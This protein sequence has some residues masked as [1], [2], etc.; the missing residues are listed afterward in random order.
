VCFASGCKT[1]TGIQQEGDTDAVQIA[2]DSYEVVTGSTERQTV[3]TGFL[4][5]GDVADLAMISIDR[6]GDRRLHLYTLG[7][8]TW[9]PR[10]SATLRPKVLFVDIARIG[11]RDRLIT[12]ESGRLNWFDP[13]SKTERLLIE[14]T[15]AYN[16][17]DKSEIPQMKITRDVNGDGYDDILMPDVD[18]FWISIQLN[19]GS[20]TNAVKLGPSEPFRSQ[21]GVDDSGMN[22]S[23]TYGEV[24]ITRLTFP[25][26][27]SRVHQVDFNQDGR[28]DL[29]FWNED[30]FDV[31]RQN[32]RG[33]FDPVP[34][35]FTAYVPFDSEGSYSRV[36]DYS[37]SGIF[38]MLFGLGE[39]TTRTVLHSMRDLNGDRVADL[40]TLAFTGRSML[41]QRS[42]Y[43]VHFG[44]ASPDGISF[45]REVGTRIHP[46][47]RAGGA[48]TWGY[49]THRFEDFD[50]DGQLDAMFREVNIGIGGMVRALLAN[51]VS[52]NLE[53]Y[54]MEDGLY[55]DK[56]TTRKIRP[57]L[58][59]FSSREAIFFPGALM[60]DVNGDGRSDLLVG[61]SREELHIY[62][63]VPGPNLLAQNPQKVKVALPADQD[64]DIWLSD[65][66]KDG[67]QDV[68]IYHSSNSEP[69][70]VTML[71][72]R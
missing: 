69:H 65:L 17:T 2:F 12:Y 28:S 51:S 63:G 32:E 34:K 3:L 64:R 31:Y 56:P 61:E 22:G 44:K 37:D 18:G 59:P 43:E 21:P 13:D 16:A 53:F 29:V 42:R 30:H 35:T 70:R 62:I 46:Q 9:I 23:R 11:G 27:Q 49:A 40:V 7:D 72:A 38:S 1:P 66:N 52:M 41:K 20:F 54:R 8:R 45:A 6:K 71:I 10:L 58:K 67:K 25:W 55:P 60:G 14:V 24:G 4:L 15:T 33:L 26:Y 50:G 36:F 57:D 68:L 19:D 48:Q 5:S 47:G 39:N